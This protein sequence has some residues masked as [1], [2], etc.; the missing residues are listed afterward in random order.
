MFAALDIIRK[1]VGGG[2]RI[3]FE[4]VKQV[5]A[6]FDMD[7]LDL[8]A[9]IG[10][11]IY[12]FNQWIEKNSLIKKGVE[13]VIPAI[14]KMGKA[15]VGWVKSLAELPAVQNAIDKIVSVFTNAMDRVKDFIERLKTLDHISL[16]GIINA[17]EK[18]FDLDGLFDGI[19]E[20]TIAGLINGLKSGIDKA[21]S[22]VVE[23]GTNILNA[24][25]G[26]L[27]IHSPSTEMFDIGKNII[28]GLFNGIKSGISG[29]VE[30]VT[31]MV[32]KFTEVFS[33]ID[34]RSVFAGGI[35]IGIV[36]TANRL[37]NV[38][39]SFA[40][41][42]ESL[43]DLFSSVEGVFTNFGKVLK[44]MAFE[45]KTEGIK[46]LAESLLMIAGAAAI[47]TFVDVGKLW[48]AVAV[49]AVLAAILV[50][51]AFATSKISK[52][53][54]LI[55]R[56]A[57]G[58]KVLSS[59]LTSIAVSL[60][61]LAYTVKIIGSLN[62]DQ[63]KQ[64]FLGLAGLV[65]A[66]GVVF[67]A[68][69]LL[70]K[71]KA[72]QNM[73]KAGSMLRKMAVTMLL[74]AIVCKLVGGL[75]PEEAAAGV[76]FATLFAAFIWALVAAT[77]TAGKNIDKV[78]SMAIK[79]SIAMLLLVGVCKLV[80]GLSP[81][82]MGKGALFAA[83][84]VAFVWALVAVTKVGNDQKFAKIGGMLFGISASMLL[85]VGVCKLVGML[86]PEDMLKGAIFAAVFVG[87]VA[88]LVAV[89]KIG[90]DQQ[91]AKMAG[92][93]L[94]MSVAIG[95]LAGVA[96]LLGMINLPN[97]A[98]GIIAVG[99]LGGV[100]TAM[101]WTTKGANDIKGSLIAMSVAIGI[102]AAAIIA[103]S[104]ID[105]LKLVAPT[106]AMSMLM[107]M[108]AL[109]TKAAG[110]AQTSIGP[111]IVM[112]VAVGLFAGI[113]YLLSGLPV[114]STL[115]VAASLSIL[116]LS[117]SQSLKILSTVHTIS[118]GALVG[119]GAMVIAVGL[120]GG[121]LGAL[122]HFNVAPSIETAAALS[123]L[124]I[125][126]S[127]A[128]V[129]LSGVGAAAVGAIAGAAALDAVI[130]IIGAL[131]IGIGALMSKIP[132][133]KIE[134]WKTGLTNFLDFIGILA[135]GLGKAIG[136]FIGGALEGLSSSLV[137]VADDLSAF[138]MHL[139]P[140]ITTIKLI[141]VDAVNSVTS[142]GKMMASLTGANILESITS[143]ITGTS[144][145]EKF[146]T[147]LMQFANAIIPFSNK[148][149]EANIDESK[150]K[151]AAN[152]GMLM[153]KL[154]DSIPKSGGWVQKILGESDMAKFGAG[155]KSF[156]SAIVGFSNTITEA[157]GVN[158]EVIA[159]AAKGGELLAKLQSSIPKTGGWA[160]KIL[161]ESDM[162]TF[163]QGIK[164]FGSAIVGFSQTV[165]GEG[166]LNEEAIASAAKAGTLMSELQGSIPKTGGWAQEI[167]GASDLATFGASIKAFGKAMTEFSSSVKVDENA[168]AAA[169]NAGTAM[170]KLEK[171][172]PEEHWLDGKVSLDD[173]GK[174]IKKF[175]EG[176]SDYSESVSDID[177]GKVSSSVTAAQRIAKLAQSLA[178]LDPSGINNF[179]AKT[180]GSAIKDYADKVD[181]IETG[182]I[183]I[184]ISSAKKLVSLIKSLK[185]LDSS[186][187]SKFKVTSLGKSIKSYSDS[188]AGI[189]P[190][191]VSVSISSIKKLVDLINSMAGLNTSGVN[192]FKSAVTSLGKINLGSIT[193]SFS[194]TV[195]KMSSIGS[196]M[197][198]SIS[199]GFKSKQS[200]FT[201]AVSSMMS[202][203]LK[204]V[205]SKANAFNQAGS[206][207]STK[208]VTGLKSK[209]STIKASLLSAVSLAANTVRVYWSSFYN[210]GIYLGS[211][212]VSGINA[213]KQA[214]Y[215][216][217]YELG[218]AAVKGEKDGQKSRSPS[219]LT[220]QAGKWLG[221]GLVI[222]INKMGSK[223]Y[224]AGHN[225]GD[226]AAKSMSSVLSKMSDFI[227]SGVDVQP[228]IRPVVD[229]SDVRT[230]ADA[231]GN[232]FNINP[233]IG[234]RSNLNA[235]SSMMSMKNQNGSFD[236]VVYAI[237]K[238]RKDLG[239]VG[240]TSYNINGITYDDGSN[241]SNAVSQLI[242]A[243][244]IEGRS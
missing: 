122:Q 23:I 216:A 236:D 41:P 71:G 217:G 7:I 241:V 134:E 219:K 100:M 40:S 244:R 65:V 101:I 52:A 235:I 131:A 18:S 182:T 91:I 215:K 127:A 156:G 82:E 149:N 171:A 43:G 196:N 174:K 162:K 227:D 228:T 155:I 163:G 31:G 96:I 114:E 211:G 46:N 126:M 230:G 20:D 226:N 44:A 64:G 73:D 99:L 202:S 157:G 108:F 238:L 177:T 119:L 152:A 78:G 191:K 168:V 39:E 141:D 85:M 240:N 62:P 160:Q 11:A 239:N 150:V 26:V 222:G 145:M 30:L 80:G 5:L 27:G 210:A 86:H 186:G 88:A 81:E 17:L 154:A 125:A 19:G 188:V 179:K 29:L 97:L 25:K 137:K 165:S 204:S 28:E 57:G 90:N 112:T 225:L 109:M 61:L 94:A 130:I 140:F 110:A 129:I 190:G 233:S 184:S 164:A 234:T 117:V 77:K 22:V 118:A 50:A 8:T 209:A 84:F 66:I 95:I 198:S 33:D 153:T 36:A 2:L 38:M 58:I 207:L 193:K 187:I 68:Y 21:V 70:V 223:V 4:V 113:L 56:N 51:L 200:L 199:R 161:G 224:S 212:L 142:L 158:E 93:I 45:H 107:G 183:S 180:I 102:M 54:V 195:S 135:N 1:I 169:T 15:I 83:A 232:M 181:G 24:I 197:A 76:L 185:G 79:L 124:I 120:L 55:G 172:I 189:S 89:T 218:Q 67:A 92:T 173:F 231:I 116:L 143:F 201:S 214:A 59:G 221:E 132:P 49:I 42:L 242:R 103:L 123:I 48:N 194:G 151:A 69:G 75:S 192:S 229:L 111:L 13:L 176:I 147:Q 213:K 37:L 205:T 121:I 10:D 106:L 105:P 206:M 47:L 34:W 139:M 138:A 32:S 98:K 170:A 87:F 208:L 74:L 167:M 136:S 104:F 63:A 14:I 220:I 60:M 72:A 237:N 159:A 243:I 9:N 203:A 146:G 6:V 16:S 3:A 115:G 133:E 148:L 12:K 166:A 144:S 35:I 53:S 175:G 178:E 128:C